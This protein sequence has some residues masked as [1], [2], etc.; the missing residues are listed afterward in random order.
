MYFTML[1]LRTPFIVLLLF[2][3][4]PLA[5]QQR[6]KISPNQRFLMQ[7]DGTPFFYLGDTA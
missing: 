5:A 3:G 7:E 6:L 4:L 1:Y 2:L